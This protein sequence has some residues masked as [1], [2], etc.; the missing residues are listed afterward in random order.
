MVDPEEKAA[1]SEKAKAVEKASSD[2][3]PSGRSVILSDSLA[4]MLKM[5]TKD[6][7]HT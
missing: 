7:L 4:C 5:M 6:V 1:A 3:L 2:H